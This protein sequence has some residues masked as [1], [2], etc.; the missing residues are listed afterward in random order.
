M[1]A[2]SRWQ[3]LPPQTTCWRRHHT[4][5]R[6]PTNPKNH[7]TPYHITISL[8]RTYAVTQNS[9]DHACSN[10]FCRML[11]NPLPK[12]TSTQTRVPFECT[13]TRRSVRFRLL[14]LFCCLSLVG[15]HRNTITQSPSMNV[16][17]RFSSV[18]LY[19]CVNHIS[20]RRL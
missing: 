4:G 11:R 15:T 2:S 8:F 20:K 1:H 9:T 10:S 18:L 6:G 14:Q 17:S 19:G 12:L 7:H 13:L 5:T 16:A 3:A